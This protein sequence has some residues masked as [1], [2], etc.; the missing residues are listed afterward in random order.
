MESRNLLSSILNEFLSSQEPFLYLSLNQILIS[1]IENIIPED[2]ITVNLDDF[3]FK[4]IPLSPFPYL[5][6]KLNTSEE[7]IKKHSYSLQQETI[8]SYFDNKFCTER[9]DIIVLEEIEYENQRIIET[10]SNLICNSTKNIVILNAQLLSEES[11]Q[12]VKKLDEDKF[13]G[14]LIL[15]YNISQVQNKEVEDLFYSEISI[16][17]NFY[18]IIAAETEET[19]TLPA[20]KSWDITN[21]NELYTTLHNMRC[22]FSLGQGND[23]ISFIQSHQHDI[24]FTKQE[25]ANL[26]FE[27]AM[28]NI[29]S[30]DYDSATKNLL[31]VIDIHLLDD[32]YKYAICFL[33][34]ILNQQ[35]QFST[36]LKYANNLLQLTAENT[37]SKFFVLANMLEYMNSEKLTDTMQTGKYFAVIDL[38]RK[39]N[40]NNN[41]IYTILCTPW[42]YLQSN[43]FLRKLLDYIEES[44]S[45]AEKIGNQFGL[46]TAC[47]W[48]GIILSK[49]GNKKEAF[50]WYRRC[51]AIRNK[52]GNSVA[53]I[54]IRNGLSYEYLLDADYLNAYDIINSFLTRIHDI[55]NY[56]EI[57]ITLTNLAKILFFVRKFDNSYLLF[58]KALKLMNIY[59]V[60][61]FVFVSKNDITIFKSLIDCINGLYTQ[62]KLGLYAINSKKD[63]F[64]TYNTK[65]LQFLLQAMLAITENNIENAFN[66]YHQAMNFI[67]TYCSE[68]SH[69]YVFINLEFAIFLHKFQFEQESKKYWK[70]GIDFAYAHQLNYYTN[71]VSSFTIDEFANHSA[72]FAPLTVSVDYLEE[73]AIKVKLKNQIAKHQQ[74]L[75]FIDALSELQYRCKS[76]NEYAMV[77]S[78]E[79]CNKLNLDAV[80]LC[81]MKDGVYSP[82]TF[83]MKNDIRII[84]ST[85]ISNLSS[86]YKQNNKKFLYDEDEH[87]FY[88]EITYKGFTNSIIIY[89]EKNQTL[90]QDIIDIAILS[91]NLINSQLISFDLEKNSLS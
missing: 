72:N 43:D 84:D 44:K 76:K 10:F 9:D 14:K 71:T 3:D 70:K 66:F 78:C 90:T 37:S 75:N 88:K 17:H 69:L 41:A 85:V 26:H 18:E 15:C 55:R 29:L 58:N 47:H 24:N 31:L 79:L 27:I 13:N 89:L 91:F 61:E 30:R 80:I 74:D 34:L 11:I 67:D 6:E 54:K 77:A 59:G 50:N 63:E 33:S 19:I 65:P 82:I 12:I 57:V 46:S 1:Y 35:S 38:L 40:F 51:N 64:I 8:L 45:L 25:L 87:L 73:L 52:I 42:F 86:A 4:K 7:L 68:Q 32:T 22:L 28:I 36:A 49:L 83:D 56:S 21:Y 62:A 2:F 53:M 16:F 5:I 81:Q 60:D 20:A 23:L 39:N 48:K